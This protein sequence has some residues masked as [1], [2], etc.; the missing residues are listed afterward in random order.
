MTAKAARVL[1]D[2][3]QLPPKARADIAGTLLE[4]L[5]EPAD[6]GVEEAWAKEIERRIREVGSGEVKLVPWSEVRRG[7]RK[8]L[9]AKRR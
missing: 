5:D 6:K 3:L 8:R 2:A 9:A 4:S 7:L 1:Q